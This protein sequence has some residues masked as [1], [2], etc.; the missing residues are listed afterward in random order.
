MLL[1]NAG[2]NRSVRIA[3]KIPIGTDKRIENGTDQL[4]YSDANSKKT[5]TIQ[6]AKIIIVML[7]DCFS[8]KDNPENSYPYPFGKVWA[9]TSSKARSASPELYPG[10][11]EPLT[12]ILRKIL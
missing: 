11:A 1:S 5:K 6:R 2:I 3:P 9:A 8:C 7:P 4:S 12:S 10:A